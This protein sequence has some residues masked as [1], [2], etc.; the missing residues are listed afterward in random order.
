MSHFATDPRCDIFSGWCCG[1]YTTVSASVAGRVVWTSVSA[2]RWRHPG[3]QFEVV[4]PA[5]GIV[6]LHG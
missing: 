2:T 5:Q 3:L 4:R 6:K 1:G